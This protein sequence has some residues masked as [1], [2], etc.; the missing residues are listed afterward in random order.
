[1]DKGKPSPYVFPPEQ[2]GAQIYAL[3]QLQEAVTRGWS[4]IVQ[5]K[6]NQAI[7]N[8]YGLSTSPKPAAWV[9]NFPGS[10]LVRL[11]EAGL[12]RYIPK[13]QRN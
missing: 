6:A 1:M 3:E 8:P 4:V 9:I 10:G 7:H 13:K 12:F 11:F 5:C 2:Y